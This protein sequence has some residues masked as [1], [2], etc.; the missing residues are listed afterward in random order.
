M[1]GLPSRLTLRSLMSWLQYKFYS[2]DIGIPRVYPKL[3][4]DVGCRQHAELTFSRIN[5]HQKIVVYQ[6]LRKAK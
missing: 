1:Q 5:C 6:Y 2:Y 3:S 4:G